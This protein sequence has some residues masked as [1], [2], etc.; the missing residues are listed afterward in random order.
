MG[1]GGGRLGGLNLAVF[2]VGKP[3][4]PFVRSGIE[5]YRKKIR[6]YASLEL[7]LVRE[8]PLRKG[9][10]LQGVRRKEREQIK[11]AMDSPYT[12]VVLEESGS[13]L[14]S[15]EFASLL[16]RWMMQGRSRLAFLVGGPCG[17]PPEVREQADWLLS[18]SPMT[19]SHEM[20]L[21]VLMEQIYRAL[22]IIHKLPYPR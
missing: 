14:G 8:E 19:F 12:W 2:H 1:G 4:I 10:S 18:L 13:P 17:L 7:Q 15:E 6:P 5:H 9:A 3:K 20:T 22:A 21:L 16:E 11:K